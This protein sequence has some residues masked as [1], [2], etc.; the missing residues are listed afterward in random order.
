ML[1]FG[2]DQDDEKNDKKN[3]NQNIVGCR[4]LGWPLGLVQHNDLERWCSHDSR[5]WY[6]HGLLFGSSASIGVVKERWYSL[7]QY[8]EL[9]SSFMTGVTEYMLNLRYTEL[10][11]SRFDSRLHWRIPHTQAHSSY[12]GAFLIP[13]RIP[14]TQA[15][16]S[17]PGACLIPTARDAN[18]DPEK[19]NMMMSMINVFRIIS[20]DIKL[21]ITVDD[22]NGGITQHQCIRST[23]Q[24]SSS[25][26]IT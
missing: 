6:V 11:H 20:A 16:S 14:H 18:I 2:L 10:L 12:P 15:H 1:V 17:Y 3:A 9:N 24:T 13:K 8:Q 5:R 26:F 7:L 25:I 4:V 21:S 19:Y 22:K 23:S